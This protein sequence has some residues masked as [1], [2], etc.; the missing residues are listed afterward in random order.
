MIE[1]KELFEEEKN[2]WIVLMNAV[3]DGLERKE[4][5]M[6]FTQQEIEELFGENQAIHMG[7]YD[8]ETLVGVAQLYLNE[9]YVKEIKEI[10][11]LQDKKV[12]ELGGYLVLEEYRNQGIMK[13][14][15]SLLI[16]KAK[17]LDYE[18]IVI[19]VHPENIASNKAVEFTGANLAKTAVLGEYLRNIYVLELK[20]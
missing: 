4:F 16:E 7:A 1:Y 13:K 2:Q 14:L 17:K 6:P 8:G 18:Y 12:I 10:I 15:E 20:K 3:L 19:T 11:G 5:F 9:S